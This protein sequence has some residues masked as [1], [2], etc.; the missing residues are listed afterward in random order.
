LGY[1]FEIVYKKGKKN[2]VADPLLRKDGNVEAFFCVIS[3]NQ[4]NWIIEERDEWNNDEKVW[5]LI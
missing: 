4:P 3:I 2:V 1:D 5:T